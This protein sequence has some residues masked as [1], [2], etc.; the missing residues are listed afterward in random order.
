[1][2]GPRWEMVVVKFLSPFWPHST[3]AALSAF[4]SWSMYKP[5]AVALKDFLEKWLVGLERDKLRLAVF[6]TPA[7][8]GVPV[9]PEQCG[10]DLREELSQ[11]G[12]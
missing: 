8:K 7:G 5:K 9:D 1:M 2:D 10:Q 4:G 11:Y 3:Y 6:P 12:E